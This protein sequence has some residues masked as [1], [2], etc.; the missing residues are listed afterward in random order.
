MTRYRVHTAGVA[1][2]AD[3]H[4][5]DR[6]EQYLKFLEEDDGLSGLSRWNMPLVI[7]EIDDGG[8][9]VQAAHDFRKA[10]VKFL[11]ESCS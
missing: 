3:F 6:A 10:L 8:D 11:G 2:L 7:T 1:P 4:F 9:D 5:R